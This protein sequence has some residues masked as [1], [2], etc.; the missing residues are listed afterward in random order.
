MTYMP[1]SWS[2]M[3]LYDLFNDPVDSFSD[4]SELKQ[5]T[6]RRLNNLSTRI[7]DFFVRK[8][9]VRLS[10]RITAVD[11]NLNRNLFINIRHIAYATSV[12]CLSRRWSKREPNGFVSN[13]Q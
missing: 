4:D 3:S 6:N 9:I 2:E 1:F 10:I 13:C 12:R 8:T 5:K 7:I 11:N